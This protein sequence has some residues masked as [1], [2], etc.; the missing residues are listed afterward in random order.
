MSEW[1]KC[2][3]RLPDNEKSVL[4]F[5]PSYNE[6]HTAEFCDWPECDDWHVSFAKHTHAVLVFEQKEVSHWQ[7][8]PSAPE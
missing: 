8:L 4:I 1:I 5:V 3:D 2:S 7:P 6:I